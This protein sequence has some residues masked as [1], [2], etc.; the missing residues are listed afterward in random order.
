MR[1]LYR[2]CELRIVF[3]NANEKRHPVFADAVVPLFSEIFAF[4]K[5]ALDTI[6]DD[7]AIGRI[8]VDDESSAILRI[9]VVMTVGGFAGDVFFLRNHMTVMGDGSAFEGRN[10]D[11]G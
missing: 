3:F 2:R 7:I 11:S 6:E 10:S 4:F 9:A 8:L 1:K 5:T